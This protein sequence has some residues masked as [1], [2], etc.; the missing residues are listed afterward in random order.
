[1]AS[2]K[3][4]FHL[5][6]FF[7]VADAIRLDELRRLLQISKPGRDPGFGHQAPHYV[8]FACPPLDEAIPALQ[9]GTGE[10]FPA[11][12]RYFDYGVVAIEMRLP[13]ENIDWPQLIQLA[14]KWIAGPELESVAQE[15]VRRHLEKAPSALVKPYDRLLSEDYTVVA[16]ESALDDNGSLIPAQVLS[17]RFGPQIAQIVRGEA[18]PLS[19]SECQE[20]LASSISYGTFD[21][22]AAGWTAALVY[23]TQP[24]STAIM[25]QLLEYANTQL[26]EFRH[27][28]DVLS[29]VLKDVYPLVDKH[30][31]PIRRWRMAREAEKLNTLRLE[32]TELTERADNAIKFLSDMFYA[33]AYRLAA[34]R[35][36]VPDYHT[37]VDEKLRTAGELYRFLMDEFHHARAFVLELTV[38]IIL[39]IDLIFLFRGKHT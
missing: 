31:G 26:L 10:H 22:M 12:L 37:L 8:R 39:I 5:L 4:S 2:L 24:D 18:L 1:M 17:D 36:G 38:V 9:L 28:D 20:V 35:I 13:F 30:P 34:A 15:A 11:R 16:I 23:D 27:Y 32:I 3:G 14:G 29:G 19:T 33:R 6:Y 7:D 25:V 21:F